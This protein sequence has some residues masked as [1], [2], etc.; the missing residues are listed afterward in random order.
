[1]TEYINGLILTVVVCQAASMLAPEGET[2]KRYLKIV[3]ALVTLLTILSPVKTFVSHAGEIG[4]SFR[5]FFTASETAE[6]ITPR[7]SLETAAYT[8]LT[9]AK[10]RYGFDTDGAEV[11]FFTDDTGNVDELM[12]FLP[13]GNAFNRDRLQADLEKELGVIVHIFLER[14]DD[15]GGGG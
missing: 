15:D 8:I 14:R 1:M 2:A 4:Q 7:D 13:S 11:T 6:E 9:Y 5:N 3:C 12:L 10:E